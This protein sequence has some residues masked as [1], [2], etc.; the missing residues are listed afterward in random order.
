MGRATAAVTFFVRYNQP[1]RRPAAG[2]RVGIVL[3][4]SVRP[5]VAAYCANVAVAYD[6][7]HS[8]IILVSK[9]F[10]PRSNVWRRNL[11]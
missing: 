9:S 4:T 6:P 10:H 7:T 5:S 2:S 1:D 8:Q 11:S 3:G